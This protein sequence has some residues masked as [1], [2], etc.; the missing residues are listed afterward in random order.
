MG[1]RENKGRE[2]GEEREGVGDFLK[3]MGAGEIG[4]NQSNHTQQ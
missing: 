3:Q 2:A 4:G 1:A